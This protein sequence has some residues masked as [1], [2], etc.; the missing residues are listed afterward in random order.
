MCP[1]LLSAQDVPEWIVKTPTPSNDT[2]QYMVENGIGKTQ[3]EAC[4][5]AIESILQN[6]AFY[7]GVQVHSEDFK[8][9]QNGKNFKITTKNFSMPL[10]K[11]CE[12]AYQREDGSWLVYV[13]CQV[14]K[15]GNREPIFDHFADCDKAT[16]KARKVYNDLIKTQLIIEKD[17]HINENLDLKILTLRNG[18]TETDAATS[19]DEGD[20]L[21]LLFQSPI[22]GFLAV[23]LT[24]TENAYCLL[25]Y[26][27]QKESIMPIEKYNKY[28]FFS[29]KQAPPYLRDIVNEYSLGCSQKNTKEQNTMYVIF[30]TQRFVKALDEKGEVLDNIGNVELP[31]SLSLSDFHV[32]LSKI[33]KDDK[34]LV[35]RTIEIDINP[36]QK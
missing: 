36:T 11:V 21:Y 17:N 20:D 35:Y 12:K 32:W 9:V 18:V 22:N 31:R 23:Y 30:S 25:P 6:I 28:V 34:E 19:F 10:Y 13:L 5:H 7:L 4:M 2:Y 8:A 29:S 33:Y 24:D 3:D 14:A 15:A 16:T 1:I 26:Q 27:D